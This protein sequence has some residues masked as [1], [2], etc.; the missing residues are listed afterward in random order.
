[1]PARTFIRRQANDMSVLPAVCASVAQI[2]EDELALKVNLEE[3]W[4]VLVRM[5]PDYPTRCEELASYW[6]RQDLPIQAN[7][8]SER[9]DMIEAIT[10]GPD[11]FLDKRTCPSRSH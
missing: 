4:D 1:M 10:L 6:N 2:L 5:Q 9:Y 7:P 11:G 8:P 3:T